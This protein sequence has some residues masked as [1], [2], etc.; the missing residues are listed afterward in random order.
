MKVKADHRAA[1]G[2]AFDQNALHK[3]FR[4]QLGERRIE[5]EDDRTIEPG[6][7]QQPQ[8]IRLVGQPEQLFLRI[9][10]GA[11]MRLEGQ[12]RGRLSQNS[13]A[14]ER[15]SDDGAMAAMHAVEI[16]DGDDCAAQATVAPAVAHDEEVFCRHWAAMV[17]KFLRGRC[18]RGRR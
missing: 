2:K 1:H 4:G 18:R 6:A 10:E 9:E 12:R 14:I 7:G 3:F 5:G 15:G 16:A 11:R 13:G 17:K 8:L